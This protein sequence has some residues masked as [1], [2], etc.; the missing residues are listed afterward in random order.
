MKIGFAGLEIAS[1]ATVAPKEIAVWVAHTR[2][3]LSVDVADFLTAVYI[4][5]RPAISKYWPDERA[6]WNYMQRRDLPT[7]DR[8]S[9]IRAAVEWLFPG[10]FEIPGTGFFGHVHGPEHWRAPVTETVLSLT[11]AARQ[12]ARARGLEFTKIECVLLCLLE[13]PVY[14]EGEALR[15]SGID[16]ARLANATVK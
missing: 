1:D 8:E 9:Q 15:A 14:G 16:T 13:N 7:D 3:A 10:S 2:Q 6:C 5:F 12:M 4:I 11:A